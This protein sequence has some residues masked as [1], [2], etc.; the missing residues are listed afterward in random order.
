MSLHRTQDY[1]GWCLAQH[2]LLAA[3]DTRHL[4]YTHLAE[5]LHRA[6]MSDLDELITRLQI[7]LA[8]LLK[9]SLGRE[10]LPHD[11]ARARRGWWLTVREQR[12]RVQ[13]KLARSGTLRREL[14]QALADAYAA[15]RLEA[16]RDLPMAETLVPETCPW[17]QDEVL[18]ALDVAT[19]DDDTLG[20][21]YA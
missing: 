7:L 8:H 6:A 1:Y 15:A 11:F 3:R 21:P 10:H 16:A 19:Q 14:A 13:A 18:E 9:L 5:E 12:V 2:A 4:D 20:A 17:T